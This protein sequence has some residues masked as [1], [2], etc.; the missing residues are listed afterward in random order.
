MEYK[1]Y[2]ISA[3]QNEST[4]NRLRTSAEETNKRLITSQDREEEARRAITQL[5]NEI[6]NYDNR[7]RRDEE[8]SADRESLVKVRLLLQQWHISEHKYHHLLD[9]PT[10]FTISI[11]FSHIQELTK[12]QEEMT[13]K[14]FEQAKRICTLESQLKDNVDT[15]CKEVEVRDY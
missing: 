1:K 12:A 13:H 15:H 14:T 5:K 7:S 8:L 11:H 4:I 2:Q 10:S 3:I 9:S 6:R